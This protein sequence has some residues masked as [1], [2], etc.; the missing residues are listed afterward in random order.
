MAYD[1]TNCFF[2]NCKALGKK[3]Q[4]IIESEQRE[5]KPWHEFDLYLIAFN[6][7]SG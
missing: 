5:L 3:Q 1:D 6:L 4:H 7:F 2:M